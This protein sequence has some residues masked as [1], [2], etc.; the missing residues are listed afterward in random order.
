MNWRIKAQLAKVHT[1]GNMQEISSKEEFEEVIS[2]PKAIIYFLVDWSL[3]ERVARNIFTKIL[4]ENVSGTHLVF[5]VNVSDD[6]PYVCEWLEKQNPKIIL[7]G[8]GEIVLIRNGN[9]VDFIRQM[10]YPGVETN[11]G[12]IN[13]WLEPDL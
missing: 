3:E 13:K 9:V 10:C 6:K 1:I 8:G 4:S 2:V 12:K 7:R 5:M 11:T